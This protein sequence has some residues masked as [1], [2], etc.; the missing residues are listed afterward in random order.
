[1]Y[2]L[3]F[4]Q[5]TTSNILPHKANTWKLLSYQIQLLRARE[6]GYRRTIIFHNPYSKAVQ[7]CCHRIPTAHTIATLEKVRGAGVD[8]TILAKRIAPHRV[9]VEVMNLDPYIVGS[10]KVCC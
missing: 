1:M 10:R 7:Y 8:P 6:L 2:V 4:F 9:T 5:T 3:I